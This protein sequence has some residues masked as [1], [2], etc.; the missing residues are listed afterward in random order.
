MRLSSAS[1]VTKFSFWLSF[2][3]FTLS[4]PLIKPNFC[5]LVESLGDFCA[6]LPIDNLHDHSAFVECLD[7]VEAGVT[8]TLLSRSTKEA[9]TQYINILRS[10]DQGVHRACEFFEILVKLI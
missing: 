4:T 8:L 6:T 3:Q 7:T 10:R 9:I 1:V 5:L 2:G